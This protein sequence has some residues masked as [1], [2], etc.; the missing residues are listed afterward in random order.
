[1][2]RGC[3]WPNVKKINAISEKTLKQTF[4]VQKKKMEGMSECQHLKI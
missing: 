3:H 1:M 2:L 4:K